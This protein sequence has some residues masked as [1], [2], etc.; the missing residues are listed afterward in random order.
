VRPRI[1]ILAVITFG[2][3]A[4]HHNKIPLYAWSRSC[5]RTRCDRPPCCRCSDRTEG[6]VPDPSSSIHPVNRNDRRKLGVRITVR[7]FIYAVLCIVALFWALSYV[8]GYLN[9]FPEDELLGDTVTVASGTLEISRIDA[10]VD[11]GYAKGVPVLVSVRARCIANLPYRLYIA[12]TFGQSTKL[13][14]CPASNQV[15]ETVQF[16][17]NPKN[18]DAAL[19]AGKGLFSLEVSGPPVP[20]PARIQIDVR[21]P[22]DAH[23]GEIYGPG[24]AIDYRT[25]SWAG[26]GKLIA[27]ATYEV[28]NIANAAQRLDAA[29]LLA[30][31]GLIG[32]L[33]AL[34]IQNSSSRSHKPDSTL[35]PAIRSSSRRRRPIL[36][37][38]HARTRSG[39][40]SG[41]SRSRQGSPLGTRRPRTRM[42]PGKS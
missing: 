7:R 10:S 28:T 35:D 24:R 39:G 40:A 2:L 33:I 9:L 42:A 14:T 21:A 29:A 12:G 16:M 41:G 18:I 22:L 26:E 13:G 17:A 23:L 4:H 15:V 3:I 6:C 32:A 31:G 11:L 25:A 20:R 1:I 19:A 36:H 30:L 27:G 34:P 38:T 37:L 5:T 8:A